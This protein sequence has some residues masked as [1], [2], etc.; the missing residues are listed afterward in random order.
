[1]CVSMQISSEEFIKALAACT[2]LEALGTF[3]EAL[4]SFLT[5]DQHALI[6]ERMT[7]ILFSFDDDDE[8]DNVGENNLMDDTVCVQNNRKYTSFVYIEE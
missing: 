5:P 6:F 4:D 8:D 3:R 1:M 7:S 2:T